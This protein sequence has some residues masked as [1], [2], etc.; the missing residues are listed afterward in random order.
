MILRCVLIKESTKNHYIFRERR[1]G[2]SHSPP[3]IHYSSPVILPKPDITIPYPSKLSHTL[4]CAQGILLGTSRCGHTYWW[5]PKEYAEPQTHGGLLTSSTTIEKAYTSPSLV[6]LTRPLSSGSK[7]S[8][9]IC[10][11]LPATAAVVK[12]LCSIN[13]DRPKSDNRGVPSSSMRTLF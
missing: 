7:S 2:A 4:Q 13:L 6:T 8:G 9:A 12:P 11:T 10:L 3:A 5:D 1:S